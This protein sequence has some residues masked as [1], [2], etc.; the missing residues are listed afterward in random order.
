MSEDLFDYWH[1]WRE[2]YWMNRYLYAVGWLT[3]PLS[4]DQYA[5]QMMEAE[6]EIASGYVHY[7]RL[8]QGKQP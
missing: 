7:H 3:Y 2:A 8:K 5:M 4:N 6:K 1:K